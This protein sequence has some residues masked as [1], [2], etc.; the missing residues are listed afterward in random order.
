MKKLLSAKTSDGDSVML[1]LMAFVLFATLFAVACH[2]AEI[3]Q[4][5]GI[6]P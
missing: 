6:C 4:Y 5:F 3:Q 2:A 1:L